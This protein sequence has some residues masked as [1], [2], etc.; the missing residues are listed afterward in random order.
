[1]KSLKWMT[2]MVLGTGLLLVSCTSTDEELNQPSET[3]QGQLTLKLSSGTTFAA[4]AT[5]AVSEANY[6]NVDN[7]TVIVTD[8][9]GVEKL[10]CKGY[11]VDSKMPLTMSIG[12][13]TVKAFYGTESPASR[14][15]FYVLGVEQGSI[16]ANQAEG[17]TVTCTPTCGRIKVSFDKEMDTYFDDYEVS[18]AGTEAL[19]TNTISWLKDDTEPWYVKLN[20]G[21]ETLTFTVTTTTKDD[22]LNS[23]N[24]EKVSTKSGS[25]TLSRNHAYKLNIKP[26]Y[27]PTAMG[28]IK[29]DITIDETTND[30]P[31]DIEVP[32]EWL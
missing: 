12:S 4:N 23:D 21:G 31:V 25:F 6:K 19:G 30:K 28:D 32:I 17:V 7:Y 22:F 11:E 10:N 14:D 26:N 27:T 24:K 18:F 13:F 1:M 29:I 16:K 3:G 9:D 20:E 15:D 5:R 2:G 8:K